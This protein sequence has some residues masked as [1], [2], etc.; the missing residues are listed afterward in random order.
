MAI[1]ARHGRP[2]EANSPSGRA[3]AASQRRHEL[4]A[5]AAP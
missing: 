5:P 2:S 4:E 1:R 3:A